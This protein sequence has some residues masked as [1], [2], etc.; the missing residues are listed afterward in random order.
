M[1]GKVVRHRYGKDEL[2][3]DGHVDKIVPHWDGVLVQNGEQILL[4][5]PREQ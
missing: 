4:C 1:D 2:L 3:Y 5:A